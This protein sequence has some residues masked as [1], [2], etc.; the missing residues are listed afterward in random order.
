M[1]PGK[2]GGETKGLAKEKQLENL[3]Y[4]SDSHCVR[5]N[6]DEQV[7]QIFEALKSI[8]DKENCNSIHADSSI[9]SDNNN[10]HHLYLKHGF[11]LCSHKFSLKLS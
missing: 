5:T 7:S 1:V 8:A 11:T 10:M 6:A 4:S 2:L 3:F 9:S